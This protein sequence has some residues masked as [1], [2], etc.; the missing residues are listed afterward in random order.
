MIE[1]VYEMSAAP[2]NKKLLL[3]FANTEFNRTSV[4]IGHWDE[5]ANNWRCASAGGLVCFPVRPF[6]FAEINLPEVEQ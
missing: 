6:C 5:A 4:R 3:G 1:W 2:R